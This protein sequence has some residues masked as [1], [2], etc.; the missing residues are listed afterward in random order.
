M[1]TII[2]IVPQLPPAINGLGDYALNLA[3]QLRQDYQIDTHFLVG[4]LSW[5][6]DDTIEGFKISQIKK[7]QGNNLSDCLSFISSQ[8]ILLHYVGYGYAQRGC[9]NWLVN[10]LMNWCHGKKNRKLITIFHEIYSS[11][12]KP[13]T[14]SFWLS[15]QQQQIAIKLYQLSATIITSSELAK[16]VLEKIT[17]T[18]ISSITLPVFSNIGEPQKNIPLSQ[19]SPSLV[20]FGTPGL[21]KQIYQQFSSLNAICKDLEISKIYDIGSPIKLPFSQL[22]EITIISMGIQPPD[23]ISEL[24]SQ[25]LGGVLCYRTDL[26]AKSTIFASYCAHGVIPM[27]LPVG[28]IVDADGLKGNKHYWILAE[29]SEK[30]KL[31][32]SMG[33][34]IANNSYYWYENHNLKRQAQI[35]MNQL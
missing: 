8:K 12:K 9:P 1:T 7:H 35:F 26:L 33:E 31:D 27:I 11:S 30:N 14:S 20:V 15:F 23:K 19:R 13:W 24:L 32:L 17:K 6:G 34:N 22:N 21:R 4:N 2:Q 25:S 16:R 3:R 5:Q 29:I 28:N 18:K 10:G